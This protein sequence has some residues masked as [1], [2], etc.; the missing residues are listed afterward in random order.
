MKTH[1]GFP[2]QPGNVAPSDVAQETQPR[3][4]P[5][6]QQNM[7][8][9]TQQIEMVNQNLEMKSNQNPEI[10]TQ[11]THRRRH[12]RHS[13]SNEQTMEMGE[14]IS[15]IDSNQEINQKHSEKFAARIKQWKRHKHQATTQEETT[16]IK[17]QNHEIQSNP[18]REISTETTRKRHRKAPK[19]TPEVFAQMQQRLEKN[20]QRLEQQISF[21]N[22]TEEEY[23]AFLQEQIEQQ[24]QQLTQKITLKYNQQREKEIAQ[25]KEKENTKKINEMSTKRK[26]ERR[27]INA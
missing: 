8:Q 10:S 23:N 2:Q 21:G 20:R 25:K 24:T 6:I 18:N 15:T 5:D 4:G 19:L 17:D 22:M 12:R 27:I 1:K 9:N 3:H 14:Q 13:S 11:T 26:K 16:E 7:G